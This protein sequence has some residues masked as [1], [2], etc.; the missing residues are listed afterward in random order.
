MSTNRQRELWKDRA[1]G[2]TYLVELE[3]GRVV[4]AQGPIDPADTDRVQRIWTEA[5]QGRMPA[6]SDLAADLERR[7]DE[8][9][10]GSP[11]S[12]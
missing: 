4:A 6:F 8:F 1:N 2:K 10:Q 12:P 5:A 7:R 11:P 3:D 9:E